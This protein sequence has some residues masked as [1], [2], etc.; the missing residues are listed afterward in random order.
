VRSCR[1]R[2]GGAVRMGR[3]TVSRVTGAS[4]VGVAV[5]L[6]LFLGG[7]ST[8]GSGPSAVASATAASTAQVEQA[9]D[10]GVVLDAELDPSTGAVILPYDRFIPTPDEN[11]DVMV[12]STV[13][14]SQCVAESGVMF[15]PVSRIDQSI[16]YSETFYGPWTNAQAEKFGFVR[17]MSDADLVA[18]GIVASDSRPA[19]GESATEGGVERPDADQAVFDE[20]AQSP[21]F[22]ALNAGLMR[23]G[24]WEAQLPSSGDEVFEDPVAAAALD[25]L[26]ACFVREGMEPDPEFLYVPL[27]ADPTVI[28]ETQISL[29][30]ATVACRDEV[31]F[32]RRVADVLAQQQAPII[33]AYLDE[34]VEQRA[35]LDESVRQARAI[36]DAQ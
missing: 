28:D 32:T 6:A 27:G 4:G 16:Y 21:D 20:C 10:R 36:L 24:P 3:T 5:V 34:L 9:R 8:A 26:D 25:D 33:V 2:R 15:D 23:D 30:L 13:L 11:E 22:E 14:L 19:E 7:C 1:C 12:A 17:P 18:N 29:A 31:D 35:D